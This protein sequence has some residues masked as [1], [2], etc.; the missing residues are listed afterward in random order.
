MI[1]GIPAE[2]AERARIAYERARERRRNYDARNNRARHDANESREN[3][4]TRDVHYRDYV[5]VGW[6]GEAPADTGYSLFGSSAG[7]EICH[8]HLTTEECFDLLLDAK[9]ENPFSIFIWFGGRY[10]WDEICRQSI[11]LR[12]LARLKEHG[13]VHWKDYKLTECEGKIYTISNGVTRVVIYEIF[14]WFHTAYARALRDYGTGT[15]NCTHARDTCQ[16]AS[17]QCGCIVCRIEAGKDNRPE[18]TWADIKEI[19][20]YMRLELALMSPLMDRVRK[21]C[22][23]AGFDPKGWYGPSA[24][25]KQALTR[26]KIYQYMDTCPE[27]VN[28][29]A[30]YAFIGGRFEEPCAGITGPGTTVDM[31]S[32]YMY[33]ALDCPDLKQGTWRHGRNFEPG[34]FALYR[35]RYHD[36]TRPVDPFKIHPIPRR[37]RNGS[38]IWPHRVETWV[39]APEA[40][41]VK[42]SPHAEFLE[43]WVFD[44]NAGAKRP[45]AFVK[46]LFEHRLALQALPK[47]N[48][49]R[50]AEMAFKW[51][52]ASIYGQ[53]ARCVGWDK[54]KKLPPRTH[55]IEWAGYILSKCRAEMFKVA[56]RC[57]N[58]LISI[59]TDSVTAMCDIDWVPI[60]RELGQWKKE[61][62]DTGLFYQNGVFYT[63]SNGEWSK[64]KARG[65]ERRNT[66]K[67]PV[68]PQLLTTAIQ[69]LSPLKASPRR[70]Y[71]TTRMALNGQ[72]KSHGQWKEHP[73]N[74]L[75]FGGGGK[76]YH[77]LKFC[78]RYCSGDLHRM[79]PHV[80]L[81]NP[82]DF[83]SCKHKLPWKD[84]DW[85]KFDPRLIEDILFIDTERMEEWEV[86]IV[87]DHSPA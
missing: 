74:T 80:P 36:K 47:D 7:H 70:K 37:L 51:C 12:T 87:K 52:L 25:A 1:V 30:C 79:M 78:D 18:F 69:T 8:P 42:D 9:Q 2:E 72:F 32:A 49:S 3:G 55:Q 15:E 35:V 28:E 68:S 71:I 67:L 57:G 16:D 22:L 81:D 33:A 56:E 76:R 45:F 17:C 66:G 34:K 20:K 5:F 82:F 6:D 44:E 11:P 43:S 19:T 21:L 54:K 29:A 63:E 38:V 40:E 73:G 60:G 50:Q 84:A 23:D 61:S 10:D 53:L 75:Y 64:G 65:M 85:K 39:W 24:L 46:S 13:V 41:L 62:F 77:N 14:G 58:K 27:P 83:S 4:H 59:D 31:N 48:P 26:N 86:E